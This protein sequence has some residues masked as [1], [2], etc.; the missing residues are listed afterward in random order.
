M[1]H[2]DHNIRSF[3]SLQTLSTYLTFIEALMSSQQ[4]CLQ[5]SQ[6]KLQKATKGKVN[7][8][9]NRTAK[10]HTPSIVKSVVSTAECRPIRYGVGASM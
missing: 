8:D 10:K 9:Q 3:F 7:C 2:C 4:H 1:T 5:C 6:L